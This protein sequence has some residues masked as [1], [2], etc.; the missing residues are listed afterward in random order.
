MNNQE[1]FTKVV[2]HLR[3][4][5]N[6]A[7]GSEYGCLYRGPNGTS[8]AVG[9][10]IPDEEYF[11]D[12]EQ[13]IVREITEKYD[14]PSLRGLDTELLGELQNIHDNSQPVR[15][16]ELWSQLADDRKLAFT[17]LEG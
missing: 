7:W 6:K 9:C 8:C 17:P 15:W 4:Q 14:L 12:M 11:A 16:E 5:G 10:L 2:T 13:K 3:K 1:V